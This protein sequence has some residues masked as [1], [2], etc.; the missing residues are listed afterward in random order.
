MSVR[1]IGSDDIARRCDAGVRNICKDPEKITTI[2]LYN[3][4]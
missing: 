4:E 1:K 3:Y 2:L